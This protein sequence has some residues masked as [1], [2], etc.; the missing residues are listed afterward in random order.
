MVEQI[1]PNVLY[2]DVRER[3]R[4]IKVPSIQVKGRTLIITG[5]WLKQASVYEEEI[6]E[7]EPVD[8]PNH[9]IQR[10]REAN[11]KADVFTFAQKVTD[12][13]PKFSYHFDWDNAAA[14]PIT[15]YDD[16]FKNRTAMD[17]RQNVRRAAKKGVVARSVPFD[18][19]FVEGIVQVFNED[20]IRQGRAFW[21]YGKDFQTVKRETSHC[22]K[23]SEFIGAY[24][25]DELIG[26]IK[27]LYTD[28]IA[29]IVINVSKHKYFEKRAP[30]ALI[31]KAVEICQQR[32]M[33][34]LTYAKYAYGKK[35]KSSLADFKR[36]NGFEPI[37]FPRYYVPLTL[38]GQMAVKL[39]LYR[40]L[41]EILPE[42]VQLMVIQARTKLYKKV[43]LPLKLSRKAKEKQAVSKAGTT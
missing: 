11:L 35:A 37:E 26:F 16:W 30:N 36:H 13:E 34:Y 15:T 22:L 23:R 28:K 8:D 33:S 42:R 19:Q 12:H 17:V 10:I 38:K 32:G 39:G 18:D 31:A 3:G 29:G 41:Q 24:L 7:G 21:H 5:K 27:L 20:P 40:G 1:I 2:T 14:I 4:M 6:L 9:F 43:L 25:G